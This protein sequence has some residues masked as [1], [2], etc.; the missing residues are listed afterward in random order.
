VVLKVQRPGIAA[1]IEHDLDILDALAQRLHTH[2]PD[3]D[4]YNLPRVLELTRRTLRRELDFRREARHL[5]IA[6]ANLAPYPFVCVPAPYPE[7]SSRH[8]LVMEY[9]AGKKLGELAPG[10]LAHPDELGRHGLH[11]SL[12]QVLDHGFFHA[13]PHP[14][15]LLFLPDGRFC[16]LDWGMTGRLTLVDREELLELILAIVNEDSRHL[17]DALLAMTQEHQAV[18]RRD[19]ERDLLDLLDGYASLPLKDVSLGQLLLDV[20]GVLRDHRLRLP[21]NLFL[22][23]KALMAAENVGRTLYPELNVVAEAEPLIRELARRRFSRAALARRFR[24]TVTSLL[25]TNRRLPQMA[26]EIVD[27]LHHGDLALRFEHANLDGL[28]ATMEETGGRLTLG[29]IL[30][31]MIIGSSMIVTTGVRP[32]LFGY[33]ALGVIGFLIAGVL[34][35]WL[36]AHIMRYRRK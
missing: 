16:L 13:D 30:G 15:N 27:K 35:L 36:A 5:Q 31:S 18:N 10:E 22:M 25:A 21:P 17:V 14:G 11:L 20:A 29:I 6:R 34:G 12:R 24:A 8:L 26:M 4:I 3:L 28:R 9:V 2:Y 33:P 32:L 7:L 19:L 1:T 23:I